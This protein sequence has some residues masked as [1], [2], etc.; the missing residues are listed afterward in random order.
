MESNSSSVLLEHY[1]ARPLEDKQRSFLQ[2]RGLIAYLD[3]TTMLE[4]SQPTLDKYRHTDPLFPPRIKL[5]RSFYCSMKAVDTWLDHR[6]ST[7]GATE[8]A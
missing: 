3:L 8:A 5:G 7:G 2:K 6:T 4:I 1:G